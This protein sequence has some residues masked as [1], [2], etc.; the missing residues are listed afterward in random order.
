M[1]YGLTY[2]VIVNVTAWTSPPDCAEAVT[3]SVIDSEGNEIASHEGVA[4]ENFAFV[5]E[6]PNLWSP[7][8][9]TLYNLSVTLGDDQVNSYT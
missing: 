9:P 2:H 1:G 8:N 7:S 4:N 6:K 5:V 3:I